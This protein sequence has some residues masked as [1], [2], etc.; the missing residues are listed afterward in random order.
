[1]N[2]TRRSLRLWTRR[3]A[4]SQPFI[5]G[6]TTSVSS[7]WS[8]SRWPAATTSA[9][10]AFAHASTRYPSDSSCA[11]VTSRTAS[12]S[13]TSSTVLTRAALALVMG[14]AALS[15]APRQERIGS[16]R[17]GAETTSIEPVP[18]T[19]L[20]TMARLSLAPLPTDSW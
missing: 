7:K 6:I 2:S 4:S 14:A 18:S 5:P 13:S 15:L 3:A 19:A 11:R 1:V 8:G 20:H 12:S 10:A 16:W 17:P 9:S